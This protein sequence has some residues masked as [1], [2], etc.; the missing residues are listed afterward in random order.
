MLNCIFPK[1]TDANI[2]SNLTNDNNILDSNRTESMELV[3][4]ELLTGLP[5]FS[6]ADV[7]RIA[8]V[9]RGSGNNKDKG[10]K[11]FEDSY[12]TDFSGM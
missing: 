5:T 1:C 2:S 10:Y 12:I 4:S 8:S 11:L 9:S 7:D 3:Y 6:F